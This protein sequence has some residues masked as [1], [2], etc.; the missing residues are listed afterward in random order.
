MQISAVSNRQC[1]EQLLSERPDAMSQG[2]EGSG[3][4]S[5]TQSSSPA[6]PNAGARGQ[7]AIPQ[8]APPDRSEGRDCS[9]E[10]IAAASSCA[11][12]VGSRSPSKIG[13]CV[14]NA[15]AAVQCL[16]E[17]YAGK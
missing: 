7:G 14:A 5:S 13:A 10:L 3:G 1:I 2:S 11:A 12:A 17:Q 9:L 15:G 8:P 6:E 16:V 4:A